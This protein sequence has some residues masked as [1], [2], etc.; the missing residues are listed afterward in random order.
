MYQQHHPSNPPTKKTNWGM[1]IL[2]IVLIPVIILG[3]V[4]AY[5]NFISSANPSGNNNQQPIANN[6]TVNAPQQAPH[7]NT[8]A[9]NTTTKKTADPNLMRIGNDLAQGIWQKY[10]EETESNVKVTFTPP[11][12]ENG[13]VVGES[14]MES[15]TN[16]TGYCTTVTTRKY[17]VISNTQYRITVLSLTCDGVPDNDHVGKVTDYYFDIYTD[18]NDIKSLSVG[19]TIQERDESVA[20]KIY[21][22]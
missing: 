5:N 20:Y 3:S 4:W 9:N 11:R 14:I 13:E 19:A 17:Q 21:R 10:N 22:Y 16:S 2:L 18:N 7:N 12:D 1:I 15:I 8:P 6:Q